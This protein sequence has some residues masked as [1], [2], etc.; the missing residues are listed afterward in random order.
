M[1]AGLLHAPGLILGSGR[2]SFEVLTSSHVSSAPDP[3]R[4]ETVWFCLPR[5]LG[6]KAGS[7]ATPARVMG[8]R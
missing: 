7:W 6:L 3:A 5:A 8:I 2:V 1:E 4:Q